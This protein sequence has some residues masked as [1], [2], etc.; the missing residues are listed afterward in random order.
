MAALWRR[1]AAGLIPRRC[2]RFK[3]KQVKLR[4]TIKDSTEE[5]SG[6]RALH[7]SPFIRTSGTNP[8]PLHPAPRSAR[9]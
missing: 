2:S 5:T 4:L 6:L 8:R 1:R 3:V 7:D 9:A